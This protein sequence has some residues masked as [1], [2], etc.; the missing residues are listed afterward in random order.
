MK[1]MHPGELAF[2]EQ[3]GLGLQPMLHFMPGQRTLVDI[4][5]VG[6]SG[7]F[8]RRGYKIDFAWA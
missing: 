8:I 1:P 6:L 3:L 2:R 4:T 5:E 7:D